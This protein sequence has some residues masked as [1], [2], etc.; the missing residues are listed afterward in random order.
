MGYPSIKTIKNGLGYLLDKQWGIDGVLKAKQI[1]AL[2]DGSLSPDKFPSVEKWIGEC[3]NPPS[4]QEKVH[5]AI[6]EILGGYGV[7]AIRDNR[8]DNHFYMDIGLV[9]VNMGDAYTPTVCYDTRKDQWI[10][11]SWGDSVEKDIKRFDV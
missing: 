5:L 9:Y 6:N 1:R 11:S 2:I 8:W 7:E 10:V 3:F 4:R